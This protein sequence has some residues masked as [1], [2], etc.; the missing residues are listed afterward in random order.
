VPRMS[1]TTQ[2][3]LAGFL[4]GGQSVALACFRMSATDNF[5]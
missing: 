1:L 3:P 5:S 2:K 4:K